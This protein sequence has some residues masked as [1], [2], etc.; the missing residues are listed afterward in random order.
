MARPRLPGMRFTSQIEANVWSI[1]RAFKDRCLGEPGPWQSKGDASDDKFYVDTTINE[2][3]VFLPPEQIEAPKLELFEGSVRTRVCNTIR[4]L[5]SV[6]RQPGNQL[7]REMRDHCV[8]ET[9]ARTR[10]GETFVP[11]AGP[12]DERRRCS[13]KLRFKVIVPDAEGVWMV[14]TG[15]EMA[16]ESIPNLVEGIQRVQKAHGA[17]VAPARFWLEDMT[18]G[19]KHCTVPR[20][21]TK[22]T[23]NQMIG[24][25]PVPELE[26]FT[27]AAVLAARSGQPATAAAREVGSGT[28]GQLSAGGPAGLPAGDPD[29]LTTIDVAAVAAD[30]LAGTPPE[31]DVF[32]NVCVAAG[33][34]APDAT[35][36]LRDY[37]ND[38]LGLDATGMRYKA[39]TG[40][41]PRV[42]MLAVRM[43]NDTNLPNAERVPSVDTLTAYADILGVDPRP[44]PNEDGGDRGEF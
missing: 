3:E 29:D 4:C 15:S 6:R 41:Y 17:I 11:F 44:T 25:A 8:C 30:L 14:R 18:S 34:N 38:V 2:V 9:E 21:D 42:V 16:A 37:I 23:G 20:V 43:M 40:R 26:A 32:A 12:F 33:A 5:E 31:G 39:L 22:M 1:Y 10:D 35:A 28:A 24:A 7:V 36:V 19:A 27:P 13:L